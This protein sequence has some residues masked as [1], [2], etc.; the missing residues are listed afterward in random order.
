MVVLALV[1]E[2]KIGLSKNKHITQEVKPC[3]SQK[4]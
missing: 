2:V 4:N 1:F 3:H